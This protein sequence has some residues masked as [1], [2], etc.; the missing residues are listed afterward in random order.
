MMDTIKRR[1]QYLLKKSLNLMD[2][3]L[4]LVS[5]R[6]RWMGS[7][8]LKRRRIEMGQ[9]RSAFPARTFFVLCN[10][11]I[12][13]LGIVWKKI[14]RMNCNHTNCKHHQQTRARQQ[15]IHLQENCI[16]TPDIHKKSRKRELIVRL[17]RRWGW[18][19]ARRWRCHARRRC[20]SRGSHTRR[21]HS[22]RRHTRRSHIRHTKGSIPHSWSTIRLSRHTRREG[23]L[24]P[25]RS[26]IGLGRVRRWISCSLCWG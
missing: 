2:K 25:L 5:L 9:T 11:C 17:S 18:R 15:K 19:H 1:T 16:R 24:W 21:S 13:R 4:G 23:C 12:V 26:A 6:D 20:H 22:R 10:L 7:M 8:N 3:A 14:K